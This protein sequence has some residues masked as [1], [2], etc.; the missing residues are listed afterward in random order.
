[1]LDATVRKAKM[2]GMHEDWV[3]AM[4]TELDKSWI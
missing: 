4:D 1:M 2:L 3:I